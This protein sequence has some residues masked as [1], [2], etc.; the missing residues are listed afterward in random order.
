MA[1]VQ[2]GKGSFMHFS[3]RSFLAGA[4]AAAAFSIIGLPR[5]SAAAETPLQILTGPVS[6]VGNPKSAYDTWQLT[7][8]QKTVN[9]FYA[10]PGR[11]I[12]T[13]TVDSTTQHWAFYDLALSWYLLYYRTGDVAWRTAARDAATNWRDHN[14]NSNTVHSIDGGI[15]LRLAGDIWVD[16][17]HTIS[18]AVPAGRYQSTLGIAVHALETGD[19]VSR[20]MVDLHARLNE[21]YWPVY[22]GVSRDARESAYSLMAMLAATLLGYDH[23]SNALNML[24]AI[25]TGQKSDGRWQNYDP[26]GTIVPSPSLWTYSY[27]MGLL[28]EALVMYDRVIGDARILP[29]LVAAHDYLWNTRWVDVVPGSSPPFGAFQYADIN[30]GQV[31]TNPYAVLNGL[32]VPAWG[33]LYA[34]TGQADYKTQGDIILAS[35]VAGGAQ[36]SIPGSGIYEVKQATQ[37]FRSTPRYLGWTGATTGQLAAPSNLIVK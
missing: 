2:H 21:L 27:M 18:R 36:P 19:G 32:I 37:E 20:N 30:S 14:I 16:D 22:D 26:K 12:K 33:Y 34:K 8:S 35:M 31:N 9:G 25:L 28:M 24:N 23:R 1:D 17:A 10:D 29:A 13:N 5:K 15:A 3:R 6:P 4:T 11:L 7:Q